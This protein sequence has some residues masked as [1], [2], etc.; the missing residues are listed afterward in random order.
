MAE[1][2]GEEGVEKYWGPMCEGKVWEGIR[3]WD[4]MVRGKTL[5]GGFW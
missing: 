5:S 2:A 4:Y 1:V 3:H